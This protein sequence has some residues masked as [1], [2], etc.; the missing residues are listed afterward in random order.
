MYL[1]VPTTRTFI[2]VIFGTDV[3]TRKGFKWESS[4]MHGCGIGRFLSF[5]RHHLKWN[6][7]HP[8]VIQK[9]KIC[10]I[11]DTAKLDQRLAA[12]ENGPL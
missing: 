2:L 10:L 7:V 1:I 9:A 3:E 12:A 8:A 6:N 4:V 11:V 5:Q